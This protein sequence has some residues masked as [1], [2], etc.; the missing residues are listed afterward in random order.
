[1]VYLSFKM[2]INTKVNFLKINL[3]DLAHLYEN[4]SK[5][6]ILDIGK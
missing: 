5:R 1:M 3:M 4:K 2:V 6:N